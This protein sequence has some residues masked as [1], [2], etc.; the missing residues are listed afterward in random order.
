MTWFLFLFNRSWRP[1][2]WYDG[3]EISRPVCR[4]GFLRGVISVFV[5]RQMNKHRTKKGDV[6][7]CSQGEC[8][9]ILSDVR[10]YLIFDFFWTYD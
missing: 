5:E 8:N 6:L 7:F 3:F 10:L 9:L 1:D 2:K 4:S